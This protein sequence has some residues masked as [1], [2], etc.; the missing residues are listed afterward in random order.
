MHASSRIRRDDWAISD[1]RAGSRFRRRVRQ[2][3]RSPRNEVRVDTYEEIELHRIDIHT[4]AIEPDSCMQI[5]WG[6]RIRERGSMPSRASSMRSRS[7]LRDGEKVA[8]FRV[9]VGA[10]TQRCQMNGILAE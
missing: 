7:W 5:A 10:T 2:N 1:A 4:G 3:Q 9:P 8:N 6:K